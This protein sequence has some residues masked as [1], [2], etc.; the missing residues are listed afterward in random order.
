MDN[1]ELSKLREAE[2]I[3][4]QHESEKTAHYS[5]LGGAFV[6]RGAP[7]LASRGGGSGRGRGFGR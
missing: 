1:E 3:N 2:A 6:N 4:Q 5:R 7:L